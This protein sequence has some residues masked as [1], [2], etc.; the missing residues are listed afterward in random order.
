MPATHRSFLKRLPLFSLLGF[1]VAALAVTIL[2]LGQSEPT[3]ASADH[4]PEPPDEIVYRATFTT[5]Q[6][7]LYGP[8]GA[9]PI[10]GDFNLLDFSWNEQGSLG[11]ITS[12]GGTID[13]AGYDVNIPSA[14]FGG[15]LGGGTSGRVAVDANVNGFEEGQIDVLYPL[16]AS[17]FVPKADKYRRGDQITIGSS[18][19]LLPGRA[20]NATVSGTGSASLTGT[21]GLNTSAYVE[22]CFVDCT[23]ELDLLP[24]SIP[25]PDIPEDVS[26]VDLSP[27]NQFKV[28]NFSTNIP[29]TTKPLVDALDLG[30]QRVK[31]GPRE[32][33][34]AIVKSLEKEDNGVP[35]VIAA[36]PTLR[37]MA[38]MLRG[39][40]AQQEGAINKILTV[41]RDVRTENPAS[42]SQQIGALEFILAN[43]TPYGCCSGE[44]GLPRVKT[45][46]RDDG[47]RLLASAS[48]SI[49][50]MT[51]DPTAF[52]NA[53]IP[54][55]FGLNSC[56]HFPDL[57]LP[58][59]TELGF[60]IIGMPIDVALSQSSKFTFT[61]TP[62]VALQFSEP[63]DFVVSPC[64]PDNT[65][66]PAD[67]V[68]CSGTSDR[69]IYDLGSDLTITVPSDDFHLGSATPTFS[70]PGTLS[71]NIRL[72]LEAD[73]KAKAGELSLETSEFQ[74]IPPITFVPEICTEL[75]CTPEVRYPGLKVPSVK[76]G[77]GPLLEQ[78]LPGRSIN[79]STHPVFDRASGAWVLE[80]FNTV[81][82]APFGFDAEIQPIADF[83]GPAVLDEGEE[84]TFTGT[85]IEIDFDEFL[86]YSWDL[87]DGISDFGDTV[88]HSYADNGLFTVT[89][90]ADDEHQLPGVISKDVQV[91]NVA[92]TLIVGGN[93]FDE[94]ALA[95]LSQA[96]FNR[97]LLVNPGAEQGTTGWTVS[98]ALTTD[99]YGP[100]GSSRP[101]RAEVL[102]DTTTPGY[103]ANLAK[104][105]DVHKDSIFPANIDPTVT[106]YDVPGFSGGSLTINSR[107]AQAISD[108]RFD[109]RFDT[110]NNGVAVNDTASSLRVWTPYTSVTLYQHKNFTGYTR[111]WS[112]SVSDFRNYKT[113][114]WD[115]IHHNEVCDEYEI[116]CW[117]EHEVHKHFG[118]HETTLTVHTH[119]G[120]LDSHTHVEEQYVDQK[121]NNDFTGI[122]FNGVLP[123]FTPSIRL[124]SEPNLSR[125]A[126]LLGT[127]LG[128]HPPT[129]GTWSTG[130]VTIPDTWP[131]RSENAIVYEIDAGEGGITNLVGHFTVDNGVWV[132][133]DGE[134]KFGAIH[135]GLADVSVFEYANIPLGD[136]GPGK[137]YVQILRSD[138]H[139]DTGFNVLITGNTNGGRP[140][141]DTPG[142]FFRDNAY[143]FGGSG[144]AGG[145]ATQTV[146][147]SQG[148]DMIDGGEVVFELIGYLGGHSTSEDL[149]TVTAIMKDASGNELARGQIGPLGS[150]DRGDVTR[151]KRLTRMGPV[152][153]G[154]R[155]VDVQ[156]AAEWRDGLDTDGYVDDLTL[157]LLAPSGAV[158]R[159]V[160][161]GDTHT[162]TVLWG[163]DP[164]ALPEPAL[165]DQEPG[166]ALML[167][168]HTYADQ[169]TYT[170]DVTAQDDD[171]GQA[172]DSFNNTVN[173][174]APLVTG[175]TNFFAVSEPGTGML[176]ATFED[177]G[178]NDAPW[179]ATINWGDGG[180]TSGTVANGQ[181]RG[182]HTYN[183]VGTGPDF[184][185]H[186]SVT[187]T[188]KDG[189][190]STGYFSNVVVESFQ[191]IGGVHAS[192]DVFISQG[193]PLTGLAGGFQAL[194]R[195]DVTYEYTYDF[196]DTTSYGPIPVTPN[197]AP[198]ALVEGLGAPDHF[199]GDLGQFVLTITVV[200]R[201]AQGGF[202]AVGTDNL[203]VHVSNVTPTV[204]AG[205]PA[206]VGEGVVL[207]RVASFTDPG[208][209]DLHRASIDWGDGGPATPGIVDQEA[210][211]ITGSHS[212]SDNG[213]YT[214][215]ITV[216]DD[217]GGLDSSTFLVTATNLAPV[218]EAGADQ[219]V[220]EGDTVTLD[221][222]SFTDS[223]YADT[224]T[225][226]IDW[227]DGTPVE[228][229]RI[230]PG[231]QVGGS[232]EYH[233][234]GIYAVQV[235][236]TDDE[237]ATGCD[238]LTVTVGN[239][240]P[241]VFSGSNK[242]VQEGETATISQ[243]A[244]FDA[245]EGDA[246][247]A[248]IDWGD[249]SS[250]AGT[251]DQSQGLVTAGH[252]YVN[253]GLYA[254][255]IVVCDDDAG[256]GEG[257]L[258]VSVSNVPT[259]IVALQL[260]SA[261]P[262]HVEGL[263]V[264]LT[265]PI[266]DKGTLDTHTSTIDWGDGTPIDGGSVAETPFGPPGSGAGADGTV[267]GSHN[268]ADN[269]TY[270]VTLCVN[271]DDTATCQTEEIEVTNAA[272][273][274]EAGGDIVVNE[275]TFI[276]L[277]PATFTDSGFDSNT[278]PSE[279]N[280][281]A[282]IDWGDGTTEPE[283]DIT[284]VETSGSSGVLT[285]GTVQAF[286]AY[287]K[288]GTY[289]ITVCVTDDDH[290]PEPVV[291]INGQGCD[292]TTV[293]VN[294]VAP[295]VD[296]G[297]DRTWIEGSRFTLNPTTFS[298]AGYAGEFTA[299]VDWGDGTNSL[300]Q[301]IFVANIGGGEGEPA[302]GIVQAA[303][304]FGDN[305]VYN[306][307]VC[308]DD[309]LAVVCDTMVATILNVA[310][311][312]D[313]GFLSSGVTTFLSG[314]DAFLGK[315]GVEQRF[316]ASA[317][318]PGSDDLT[319]DWSFLP[320][321][322][323]QLT[324]YFNEG[325]AP[326]GLPSP[327]GTFP[328]SATDAVLAT[329]GFPGVYT[330]HVGATDDDAGADG[331]GLPLVVVDQ[332]Q[333]S[334]I[335]PL[336]DQFY[337]DK[338]RVWASDEVLQAYLNIANFASGFFSG[339]TR[340]QAQDILAP[341]GND[342][343]RRATQE[344]L[345]GWLNF[346][347]GSIPW[348][349][350][351]PSGQLFHQAMADIEAVLLNP[352]ATDAE[353][354]DAAD[355]AFSINK[356]EIGDPNCP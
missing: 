211:T 354:K 312:L 162:G 125:A 322:Q 108:F 259:E 251:V 188:D 320:D 2:W 192:P 118:T 107:V 47:R 59:C 74:L 147:V 144:T 244:F 22:I 313:E 201:N 85:G 81:T 60:T 46:V 203:V 89:M 5:S 227:N 288:Y 329:F 129:G 72:Y 296:A 75:G 128:E 13:F 53:P 44:V 294:N 66:N 8:N 43:F 255:T 171:G 339:V 336:L 263:P 127:W 199:Y 246:H 95:D 324:T 337:D 189:G 204:D 20:L 88:F 23:G 82:G 301:E 186:G 274:V 87:G 309:G 113:Y 283:V 94:G 277:D 230:L 32:F 205:D 184:L 15:E 237:L 234:D 276:S 156:I 90:V 3:P 344:A 98:G 212:Y 240:E 271:D 191:E 151:L 289:T 152:P 229:G 154:T 106:L 266:N 57:P 48:D 51:V 119:G 187:V 335:V 256:C 33:A 340:S 297:A 101:I 306:V 39:T 202:V 62:R 30:P 131:R 223:G 121:V 264:T 150:D 219:T 257:T 325:V 149:A 321:A 153:P 64:N 96:P 126:S 249:G 34:T 166:F 196:G 250:S 117:T 145:T 163:D 280:F 179:T 222:T 245:G 52:I 281:T 252:E 224:H 228:A 253:D 260:Q 194:G 134:F 77:F 331:I 352:A 173:N 1:F 332:C 307:Q 38:S 138:T 76:T 338:G 37:T 169:G 99:S 133:V 25:L 80:G 181:V 68:V 148:A 176:V 193:Q 279:E 236:V 220:T 139:K 174:V 319:F 11:K 216:E 26:G 213:A 342:A 285:S 310:P 197:P 180:V 287:G 102:V 182:S 333:T 267:T 195:T 286:H 345:G 137:H 231:R 269:G 206:T 161:L 175:V 100:Q 120:F 140:G 135:P 305:S 302:N 159:D 109:S 110:Y 282:T 254:V 265:A 71:N 348:D 273:V 300:P 9:A 165:V 303:H 316:E 317:T 272:P 10:T 58:G 208:F 200:A 27:L 4:I 177:P 327:L 12:F 238:T 55:A 210:R 214:V 35:I 114:A 183:A 103:Y 292:T 226:T 14:E 155:S 18:W 86:T 111:T 353:L 130:P 243:T 355:L 351:V 178:V 6:P 247:T 79:D 61:P 160:G 78:G 232:H 45:R 167:L 41:A 356:L 16:E 56:D 91:N 157:R 304:E 168:T 248:T 7:D 262:A 132:W 315:V 104:A 343:L 29:Q 299:T 215:T 65:L 290:D 270:T 209:D 28:S 164:G 97:Q 311:S 54:L 295:Q 349:V 217:N 275:G 233:D 258:Q 242:S 40:S 146:D 334:K 93:E 143:F 115:H 341:G 19:R 225:A 123:V 323:T 36:D 63:V 328:F 278:I 158:V 198:G 136:V 84:G 92:P 235:C 268:Y 185:V 284:L 190:T 318:D 298:D 142:S 73:G 49:I 207:T 112:S 24:I 314:G 83:I 347:N 67:P 124:A 239:T 291:P 350:T 330:A 221:P 346:A 172:S 42:R 31:I 50:K 308:V 261:G 69:V 241:V 21:F 141:V 218:V 17:L 326:D 70:L 122:K 170:V 293:T 116:V 105:L